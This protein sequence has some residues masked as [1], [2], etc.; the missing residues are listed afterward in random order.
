MSPTART[1][2]RL[3]DLGAVAEI[4]EHRNQ[5]AGPPNMVCPA[6][7]KNRVGRTQD[8][9]GVIDVICLLGANCTGIQVTSGSNHAARLTKIKAEPRVRAWLEAGCLLELW[10][11]A[12]RNGRWVARIQEVTVED[13]L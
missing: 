2:K 3:R 8:F 12:K 11:W 13:L 7:K 10:S 6:C 1:L 9:I 4:V 5:Y